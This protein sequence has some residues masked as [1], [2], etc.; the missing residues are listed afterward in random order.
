[1]TYSANKSNTPCGDMEEL[2]VLA[3]AGQELDPAEQAEVSEHLAHCT[4]CADSFEKERELLAV[5]SAQ[6][7]EPDAALLASCRAGL[8]DALDRQEERGWLRRSLAT[9][10]PTSWTSPRPAWSAAVL[11]IVGFSVGIFGPRLFDHSTKTVAPLLFLQQIVLQLWIPSLRMQAP[12][13]S[14]I[15]PAVHWT[16]APLKSLGLMCCRLRLEEA[17]RLRSNCS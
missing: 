14:T 6:H 8:E 13:L 3:A 9:F 5:I 2:L 16:F 10:V 7:S 12:G 1:M 17:S 15:L 4:V 11:V